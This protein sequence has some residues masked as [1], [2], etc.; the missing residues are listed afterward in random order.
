[1]SGKAAKGDQSNAQQPGTCP[2]AIGHLA[3]VAMGPLTLADWR[4]LL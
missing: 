3:H 1:M 4:A 2:L